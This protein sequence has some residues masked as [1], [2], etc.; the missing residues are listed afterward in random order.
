MHRYCTILYKGPEHPRIWISGGWARGREESWNQYLGTERQLSMNN[1]C[2]K[3]SRYSEGTLKAPYFLQHWTVSSAPLSVPSSEI[4]A[5]SFL[6]CI[7]L[8]LPLKKSSFY[9]SCFLV[10]SVI[11]PWTYSPHS[12]YS[13]LRS[14]VGG[15]WFSPFL[16]VTR[17]LCIFWRRSHMW[18]YF[19]RINS[20]RWIQSSIIWI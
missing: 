15:M 4:I 8:L 6:A 2:N 11:M 3:R 20:W 1:S 5:V 12:I 14:L 9:I 10:F 18:K 13:Q 7:Y 16:V 19:F 17:F